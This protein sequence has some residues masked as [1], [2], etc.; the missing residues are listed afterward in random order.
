MPVIEERVSTLEQVLEK[1][2]TSV[3]IEFNKL[4]NSQM[5]TESELREFKDEISVFKDEMKDFKNEML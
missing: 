4:Y 3:G 5:R 1:F 2:I